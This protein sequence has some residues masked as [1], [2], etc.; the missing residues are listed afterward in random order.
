MDLRDLKGIGPKKE[1]TLH[2]LGIFSLSDLY[3][4]YP[5]EYE[6]RSKKMIVSKAKENIKYFF[7]WKIES[8]LYF[9]RHGKYNLT[10][11]YASENDRKIKIIYFNDKFT[12]SK[13]NI[14]TSYNFYTKI[15]YKN[16]MY[17]AYN[18]IF[19]DLEDKET[20]GFIVAIYPLT[21]NLTLKQL[22][23]FIKQA[24]K[25]YD[26]DEE[27]ISD[28]ILEKFNINKRKNNLVNIHFPSSLKKLKDAKSEIKILDLLKELYFMDL[29][30]NKE[31]IKQDI[32]LSYDLDQILKKLDFNLT[33]GQKR[34]LIDILRDSSNEKPMN[35]L[36]CGD[37]GSGKTIVA[38]IAMIVFGINGYQSAMM[39]PTEVLAIQQFEKNKKFVES[40]GLNIEIITSSTK[41][42]EEIKNKLKSGK[43]DIIIGTHALIQDDVGFRNLRLIVNDEQHRFGVMQRQHLANK[44][45]NPNYLT[46]TATPIPR[47]LYLKITNLL[48]ISIIDELPQNRIPIITEI[49]SI[50]MEKVLFEKINRT[51]KQKRQV[52]I[53]S[54]NIDGESD[55]S[56]EKLY[57]EYKKRFSAYK[58]SILHGKLN[59]Y[60]K[61]KILKEFSE[62]LIDILIST[63]VIEVGIDVK[64]ASTMIIYNADNFGLSTLHQLRGRVGRGPYESFCY[65]ISHKENNS[66]KLEILKKNN[67]GFEIAKYDLEIRG[68]GKIL[69]TIQH[70]KNLDN[71]DYLS[72]SKKEIDK[73]FEIYKFTKDNNFE[74]VNLEYIKKY[75]DLEK[76]I[77]L[78]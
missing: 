13:L 46:M 49:I 2:R 40:F 25:Y 75:F 34:S 11:L 12:P 7:R 33:K 65:L 44:G 4:F 32:R 3:N 60:D 24:L 53:V 66:K 52:Y 58:I 70:G 39:V 23:S 76:R 29:I 54:N 27:I 69:S 35:R 26:S 30:K 31:F 56:C 22:K 20:I 18:P 68:G 10:Y 74:G 9:H 36:M 6:D 19:S 47:T 71:I 21:K 15:T 17:E 51:L 61:E 16:G 48:D 57:N 43:I 14:N 64:N 42:K 77:I 41:N 1:E 28:K 55:Y 38:I 37:V 59:S 67:D 63:T 50:N 72:M 8:K 62:G 73:A 5:R 45:L 78:N